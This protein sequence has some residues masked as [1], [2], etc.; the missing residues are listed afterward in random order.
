MDNLIKERVILGAALILLEK[1]N[2]RQVARR[3]GCSKS[4]VHK[5]LS[6]RLKSFDPALYLEV[7][8][9]FQLNKKEKHLRGGIAT[10]QKYQSHHI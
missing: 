8:E 5:D 7:Q 6:D 1:S 2:V 4:T 10:K 9:L 3:L